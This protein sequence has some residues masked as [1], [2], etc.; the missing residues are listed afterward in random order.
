M[1]RYT[2]ASPSTLEGVGLHLGKQ[3]RL[4]FKPAPAEHGIVLRRTDIDGASPIK[5]TVDQVTETERRTQL[6]SGENTVHTVEHVLA[7]VAAIGL[8]RG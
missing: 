1:T 4:T 5:A 8:N 6:G 7:A 2:V 3:C